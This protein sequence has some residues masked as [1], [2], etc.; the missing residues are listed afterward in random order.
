MHK[1]RTVILQSFDRSGST[2]IARAISSS[3][4]VELFMQ[5]FNSGSIRERMYEIW[6]ADMAEESDV[7]FFQGL[8]NSSIDLDYIKSHWFA[9]HSTTQ[10]YIPGQLHLIKTTLNHFTTAWVKEQFPGIDTWGIWRDPMEV[11]ISLERNNFINKW[12]GQAVTE[13]TPTVENHSLFCEFRPFLK[14]IDSEIKEAAFLIA[15]RSFYLFCHLEENRI[16]EYSRFKEK[17]IDGLQDFIAFYKIT[18]GEFEFR[19]SENLIGKKYQDNVV[20]SSPI[21]DSDLNFAIDI[22]K[23]LKNLLKDKFNVY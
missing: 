5:P 15:V 11:L 19:S 10:K 1:T 2:A 17:G 16:I 23:P 18:P 22:F 3:N 21:I 13:I 20:Q 9:E 6:N 4:D 8:E 7:S 14:N 12:Y